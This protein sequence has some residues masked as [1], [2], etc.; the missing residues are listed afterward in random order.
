LAKEEHD[1]MNHQKDNRKNTG[2]SEKNTNASA[3][4]SGMGSRR[5]LKQDHETYAD[6]SDDGA[7]EEF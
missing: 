2:S 7:L 6:G 3:R 4:N 1:E 5:L